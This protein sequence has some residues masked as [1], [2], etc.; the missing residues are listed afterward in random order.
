MLIYRTLKLSSTT[1]LSREI[2]SVV[3]LYNTALIHLRNKSWELK[4]LLY[5]AIEVVKYQEREITISRVNLTGLLNNCGCMK[6]CSHE[7]DQSIRFFEQTL[8]IGRVVFAE[9]RISDSGEVVR[10]HSTG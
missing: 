1:I 9:E 2:R 7:I 8:K 6:Y 4:Q 10:F 5:I 3:M